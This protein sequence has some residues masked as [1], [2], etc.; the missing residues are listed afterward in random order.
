MTY[1]EYILR[2][3]ID[4]MSEFLGDFIISQQDEE[5]QRLADRELFYKDVK[6]FLFSTVEIET[7]STKKILF[8]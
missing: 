4:E 7:Y 6:E 2:M 3:T 8:W 1:Y 5:K